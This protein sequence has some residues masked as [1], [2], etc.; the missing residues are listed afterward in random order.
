MAA[1][2]KL[3]KKWK[4]ADVFNISGAYGRLLARYDITKKAENPFLLLTILCLLLA[5]VLI[6]LVCLFPR[7]PSYM[8][9]EV[10]IESEC[11]EASK[12]VSLMA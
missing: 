9:A 10:C 3:K 6:V 2:E 5:I 4:M 12:Q 8:R 7:V 1:G 11:L